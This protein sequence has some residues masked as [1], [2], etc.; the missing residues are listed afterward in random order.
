VYDTGKLVGVATGKFFEKER[1]VDKLFKSN[2]SSK[3]HGNDGKEVQCANTMMERKSNVI[4]Q[5]F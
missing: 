5:F 1:K 3:L 4:I 2:F